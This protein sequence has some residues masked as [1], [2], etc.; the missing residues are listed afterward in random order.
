[1]QRYD[2]ESW[3][4][5]RWRR[6]SSRSWTDR[7]LILRSDGCVRT[8]T[9]SRRA[10]AAGLLAG[11]GLAGWL[12]Y[13]TAIYFDFD[14]VVSGNQ[15][16][17]R[18]IESAHRGLADE[19]SPT[20]ENFVALA[21]EIEQ[22][23]AELARMIEHNDA[24][25]SSL[26]AT[27]QKL[28]DAELARSH[29][30]D[31]NAALAGRV[32]ALEQQVGVAEQHAVRLDTDLRAST[33]KLSTA[34]A[35]RAQFERDRALLR[36]RVEILEN[37]L[38]QV[39]SL[40]ESLVRRMSDTMARDIATAEKLLAQVGIAPS[41][42]VRKPARGAGG[43]YIPARPGD[44]PDPFGKQIAALLS[45][46]DRRDDL[47]GAINSLPLGAPLGR[48]AVGS[49]FGRR[50]DPFNRSAAFHQGVDLTAENKTP[51]LA[52]ADG[53]VISVATDS[54][55][56]RLVE[57]DHGHNLVTRY[58]HLSAF[59]VKVG[60]KV[61]KGDVLGLVGSTGRSTGPH[62]HYEITVNGHPVDP[63]RFMKAT[64]VQKG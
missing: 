17:I 62:L 32:A 58:G 27:E 33:Q 30:R 13:A 57:V 31:R 12:G 24:L 7:Q 16:A 51:V 50:I 59:K 35:E 39:Q 28:K 45:N 49:N 15:R 61:A 3:V 6:L 54:R 1:M 20:R 11:L 5:A 52:P 44:N 40:Q 2:G 22:Y 21:R 38:T 34:A 25:R 26:A 9:V 10:Q 36:G 63:M 8:V 46:L 43:P 64:H 41:H 29:S 56:G 23:R 42:V 60:Q 47:H 37:Q 48:Y 14:E 4:G 55:L 19:T 18:A 53:R